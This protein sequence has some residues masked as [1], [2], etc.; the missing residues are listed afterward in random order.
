MIQIRAKR[1]SRWAIVVFW[2]SCLVFLYP[3]QLQ[4][5]ESGLYVQHPETVQV[6]VPF[7]LQISDSGTLKSL[8]VTWLE[9]TIPLESL[10]P[11]MELLLPVPLSA[12]GKLP[13]RGYIDPS[14]LNAKVLTCSK[15]TI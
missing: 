7:L 3:M 12:K 5:K 6:G 9:K 8:R 4:A 11:H 13:L 15:T 2:M 14:S 10:E 1:S